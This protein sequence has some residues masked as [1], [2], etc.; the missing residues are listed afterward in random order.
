MVLLKIKV[1]EVV[2]I[3]AILYVLSH[4]RL[5]RSVKVLIRKP[6]LIRI[7]IAT[8]TKNWKLKLQKLMLNWLGNLN[9]IPKTDR[10]IYSKLKIQQIK[11]AFS[12]F[13]HFYNT[14]QII[15]KYNKNITY[16]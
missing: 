14:I 10:G 12:Y 1:F 5:D 7:F 2:K 8:K 16:F 9:Q 11:A 3:E 13:Y 4:H 15:Q 6:N